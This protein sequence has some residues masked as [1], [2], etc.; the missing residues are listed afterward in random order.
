VSVEAVKWR[1]ILFSA[2]MI[3][4][5][6]AGT[7]T[8]T[9]RIVR[10]QSLVQYDESDGAPVH[11]HGQNCVNYCDYACNG[12]SIE[13][14]GTLKSSPYGGA[15]DRLWVREA[16]ALA[17][18]C[19]DPDPDD[20]NDW[21]VVYRADGDERPLLASTDENAEEIPPPWRP[22]IYM[23]RWA[24]R[25]ELDITN[26]RVERLHEITGEDA[27]AEG[28]EGS[29]CDCEVCSRSGAMCPADQ[30]AHILEFRRL[31]DKLNGK[32]APW[33]SNPWVWRVEFRRV[34]P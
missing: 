22:S 16:F 28:V 13:I 5:I 25:L 1:P 14:D 30:S 11:V 24:S 9:R 26:V 23:P 3:R 31:W 4:A 6:L 10:D 12:Y 32:R 27:A 33:S 7:K 18:A 21:H 2:P 15:G 8:V 19:N 34:K 29:R 20:P 17:P